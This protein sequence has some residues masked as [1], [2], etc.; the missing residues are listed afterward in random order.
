MEFSVQSR[1]QRLLLLVAACIVSAAIAL[2][3]L[4]FWLAGRSIESGRLDLMQRGA[5]LVPGNGESWDR[6][7][8]YWQLD[9]TNPDSKT[10]VQYYLKAV[11]VDP[12][13]SFYWMDLASAYEDTGDIARARS[14][15]DQAEAVY[16]ISALVA[17]NYGNFLVRVGDYD[18][19]YRK[20]QKAVHTDPK[21]LPLA[22]SRTWRATT[23]VSDLLDKALPP[24]REAYLQALNFFTSIHLHDA[25]LLAWR[26]LIA[27]RQPVT[28][29][30][31]LAFQDSLIAADAAADERTVWRQSLAAAGIAEQDAPALIRNG[32]FAHDFI[33]GGLG[34]RWAAPPGVSASFD[35]PGPSRQGRSIRLD[36]TGGANVSLDQPAQFVTVEP[37]RA[38]RF[39][40]W[41]RTDQITTESGVQFSVVDPNHN[42]DVNLLTDNLTGSHNWTSVEANVAAGPKTHFLLVRLLR[43]PSRLFDNKISGTVWVS[44]VSLV[45]ADAG[46]RRSP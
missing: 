14:A 21:L 34:W 32:D 41:L 27:L 7:G 18:G 39:H 23:S 6:V 13:S 17:W 40:A 15:F 2:Q 5:Q 38:Y 11:H 10:A 37:G 28:I 46:A 3:A 33:N 24:D 4:Q 20:V 12:N 36:F 19:G 25:A 43:P 45:P 22:I 44:D 9:F 29:A 8:R 30:E 1:T 16:P 31:T 35:S 26:K 42:G